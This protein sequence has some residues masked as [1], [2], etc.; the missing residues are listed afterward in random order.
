M[1]H[2]ADWKSLYYL[3]ECHRNSE[4]DTILKFEKFYVDK[5]IHTLMNK[6]NVNIPRGQTHHSHRCS[7][8]LGYSEVKCMYM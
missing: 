7:T 6:D 3:C 4:Q 8:V 2:P 5:K 1:S